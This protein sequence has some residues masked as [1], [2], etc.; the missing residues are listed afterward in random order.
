MSP[1]AAEVML[2][3]GADEVGRGALAG[4]VFAAAVIL[5]RFHGIKGMDD[6][7]KLSPEVRE[8][9]APKIRRRAL[10][11]AVASATLEEI[12]RLNILHASM[13]AMRRAVERLAVAPMKVR[14]DGNYPPPMPCAV[15]TI[16][17]GDGKVGTIMAASIL[18]KVE[19]DAEM[20]RLH[21]QFPH[22][23]FASNKGYGTPEHLDALQRLGPCA[24]HRRLFGPVLQMNLVL[25]AQ[26]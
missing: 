18:A 5:P 13:L 6:S 3:A 23:A 8:E 1:A 7:K 22:Y 2:V 24:M 11:W 12:E 17:G 21:E 16:V 14:V 20:R 25:E 19:R 26:E 9:L 15:E 10:A 4:P